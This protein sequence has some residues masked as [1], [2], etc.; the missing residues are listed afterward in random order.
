MQDFRRFYV[1]MLYDSISQTFLNYNK[2]FVSEFTLKPKLFSVQSMAGIEEDEPEKYDYQ[3]PVLCGDC[4]DHK[5]VNSYCRNCVVDLCD[6]CKAR[7]LHKKHRVL[8]R[9]HPDVIR[10]RK[11]KKSPCKRHPEKLC[12]TYCIKCK[13]PCCVI[14][15]TNDHSGHSFSEL[16]DAAKEAKKTI[17]SNIDGMETVLCSYQHQHEDIEDGIS[18]YN[19]SFKRGWQ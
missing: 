15:A 10:A 17:K 18:Q 6:K 5:N 16:D 13:V 4:K 1:L 14:C 11:T 2:G 9:T 8:P 3:T 7:T 19:Q 12:F